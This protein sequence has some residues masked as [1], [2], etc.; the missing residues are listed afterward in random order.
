[1]LRDLLP[2]A[3]LGLAKFGVEPAIRDRLLGVIEE[4][5]RTRRNGAVWQSEAVAAAER[6]RRLN[7]PAALHDMLLRYSLL[8]H[9][10]QPVHT[11]PVV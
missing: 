6:N 10:N 4:R 7:R 2:K 8:Q 5:C 9:A 11:W 1:M 3:Y